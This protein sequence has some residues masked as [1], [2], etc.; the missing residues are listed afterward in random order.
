MR[1]VNSPRHFHLLQ[2]ET[3]RIK[4]KGQLMND[5]ELISNMSQLQTSSEVYEALGEAGYSVKYQCV[6]PSPDSFC[7]Q[8]SRLHSLI[9]NTEHTI[10]TS[11]PV[12]D[13]VLVG[14]IIWPMICYG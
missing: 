13:L 4:Q 9:K 8:G 7:A 14:H 5:Y 1:E 12:S 10:S 6:M 3:G 2:E 11:A